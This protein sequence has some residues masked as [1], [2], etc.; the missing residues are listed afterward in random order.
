VAMGKVKWF[1]LVK[2][3]GFITPDDGGPDAFIHIS[4]VARAGYTN[5]AEGAIVHYELVSS[6][7]G[8]GKMSAGNLRI[9]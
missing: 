7:N 1:S 6:R 9:G 3:Y 8:N 5:L 4:A 2:G